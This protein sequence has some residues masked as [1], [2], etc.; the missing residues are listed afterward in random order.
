M[1]ALA[2]DH[3]GFELKE[4]IKTYLTGN[5]YEVNDCGCYSAE[6]CDYPD[7]TEKIVNAILS[8]NSEKGIVVCGTG[9]GV[10][11]TANKF[12]GIRAAAVSEPVTARFCKEHNNANIIC[13]GGRMIGELM[14]YE[15]VDAWL[16][17]EF[18]GGR[19]EERLKKLEQLEKRCIQK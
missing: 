17:A 14:A 10:S 9:I 12:A 19:H 2:S 18:Q 1:I 15:C 6:R 13:L 16:N 7:I 4:K 11:V 5:G 3:A 8:G